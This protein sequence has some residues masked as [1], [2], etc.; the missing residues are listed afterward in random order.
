MRHTN[1][2]KIV[3]LLKGRSY[4]AGW[5]TT[6]IV[7][8]LLFRWL[9]FRVEFGAGLIKLRGDPCWRDLT[10]LDYHYQTQP[11]PN[12]LSWYAH[13]LPKQWHRLAVVGN[14]VAQ[15]PA[16]VLLFAP[17]PIASLAGVV[18][19]GTQL[20]LVVTGNYSWLNWLTIAL[21]LAAFDD[22]TLQVCP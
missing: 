10:C 13:H 9:L 17:Q 11:L 6:P 22:G 8:I 7:V 4:G 1:I 2:R 12:P 14:Y 15:L 18:M 16:P 21:G 5:T 19:I 20:W 3:E